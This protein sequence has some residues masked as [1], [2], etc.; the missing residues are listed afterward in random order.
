M[1]NHASDQKKAFPVPGIRCRFAGGH[2][3]KGHTVNA[4]LECCMAQP[5]GSIPS[6]RSLSRQ[7]SLTH[8]LKFPCPAIVLICSSSE[9]SKRMC[10]IVLPLRSNAFFSLSSC[11]GSYQYYNGK[12]NGNYHNSANQYQSV[13]TAKPGSVSPLTGPLT[14]NDNYTIEAAMKNNTTAPQ[15]FTFLFLAVMR[16]NTQAHPHREQISA[17]SEREARSLLAGRFVL[18]FAGRLPVREVVN[19]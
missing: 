9:S 12:T 18:I 1:H 8:E 7:E 16:A 11:I 5:F 6:L 13:K 14:T 19:A 3:K 10:F 15:R 17:T 2:I 4:A